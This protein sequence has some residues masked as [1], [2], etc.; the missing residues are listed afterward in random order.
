MVSALIPS[1]RVEV[2]IRAVS[3]IPHAHLV[4]AGDGPSRSEIQALANEFL[5]SRFTRI[6]VPSHRM[7]VLYHSADVFLHLSKEESFGNVFLEAMAAG[8]PTVAHDSP[9]LRWIVGENE[10]LIRNDD[11]L[12]PKLLEASQSPNVGRMVRVQRAATFSWKEIA[13]KY[14]GFLWQVVNH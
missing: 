6:S 10:H 7:P 4:V 12:V 14:Q 9:R 2:G 5:P 13:K 11:E 1:K 8:L 3:K